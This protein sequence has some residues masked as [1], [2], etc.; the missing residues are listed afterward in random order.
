[1]KKLY[2]VEVMCEVAVVAESAEEAEKLISE[3]SADWRHELGDAAYDVTEVINMNQLSEGWQGAYPY[4][5]DGV[6]SCEFYFE[7][8]KG[9]G[10]ES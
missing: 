5:G 6:H 10:V 3:D 9:E 8:T 2:R 7:A 1:M 4:G